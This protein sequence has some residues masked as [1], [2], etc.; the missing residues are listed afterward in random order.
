[1]RKFA[2]NILIRNNRLPIIENNG[3][4]VNY[5]ILSDSDYLIELKKKLLEEAQEVFEAENIQDLKSE[6]IDAMEVLEHLMELYSIDEIEL[7]QIKK[8]KQIKIG[9][10]DKKI[11]T[12]SVE[13]ADDHEEL[14][15][16]LSKP[17]KYPEIKE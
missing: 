16:Y 8:D 3:L 6:I 4:I 1:M 15:Y 5:E 10:F 11:K 14:S 13:M 9:K 12:H 2:T 7:K 17:N